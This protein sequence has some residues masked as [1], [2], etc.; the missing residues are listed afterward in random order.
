MMRTVVWLELV[1][2]L[3]IMI[4]FDPMQGITHGIS[5]WIDYMAYATMHFF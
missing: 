5:V 4:I 2:C 1:V 3:V